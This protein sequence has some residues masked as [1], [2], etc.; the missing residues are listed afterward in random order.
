MRK[1]R[2]PMYI[3]VVELYKLGLMVRMTGAKGNMNM[4][5]QKKSPLMKLRERDSR[6]K[7][8]KYCLCNHQV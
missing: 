4:K 1:P 2:R 7:S 8:E 3:P 6:G 5:S